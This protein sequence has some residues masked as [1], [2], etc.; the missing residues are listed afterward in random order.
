MMESSQVA[1]YKKYTEINTFHVFKL[2]IDRKC[3]ESRKSHLQW[4]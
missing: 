1:E 2:H 3:N 4:Q